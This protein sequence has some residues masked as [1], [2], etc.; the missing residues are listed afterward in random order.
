[1]D[2]VTRYAVS[3]LTERWASL[4]YIDPSN[5]TGVTTIM[6]LFILQYKINMPQ[7]TEVL[8]AALTPAV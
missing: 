5:P 3:Q 4:V 6:T 1:M 7:T 8:Q 2:R